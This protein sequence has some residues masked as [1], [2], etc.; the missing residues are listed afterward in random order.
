MITQIQKYYPSGK[1]SFSYSGE[2]I[3]ETPTLRVIKAIF[4]NGDKD[5]G[6]TTFAKGD[7]FTEYFYKSQF[8]NILRIESI[9]TGNLKGWYCNICN[10]AA[11][12]EESIQW[13]DLYLDLWVTPNGATLLLDEDEL[14]FAQDMDDTAKEMARLKAQS[15]QEWVKARKGTF[16]ELNGVKSQFFLAE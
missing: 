14:D 5:L 12:F 6:Y 7:I 3:A 8:F 1:L 16:M 9:Q 10:P 4:Q 13:T 2:I 11:F 15:V